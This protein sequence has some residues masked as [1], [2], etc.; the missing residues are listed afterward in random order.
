MEDIVKQSEQYES[1][2]KTRQ[3][4]RKNRENRK[5]KRRMLLMEK[6]LWI[7]IER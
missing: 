7:P 1:E 3:G 5:N 4:K 6:K 2:D